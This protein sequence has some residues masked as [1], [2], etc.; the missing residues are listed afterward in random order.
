[1]RLSNLGKKNKLYIIPHI[2]FQSVMYTSKQLE[3]VYSRIFRKY[4]KKEDGKLTA[5]VL[6]AH[7]FNLHTR[8]AEADG[9]L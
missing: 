4:D 6:V 7:A 8:K 9:P 3:F 2:L 1:M 5:A